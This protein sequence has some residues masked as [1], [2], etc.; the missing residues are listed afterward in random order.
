MVCM[1]KAEKAELVHFASL[2]SKENAVIVEMTRAVTQ[3]FVQG[4]WGDKGPFV[5]FRSYGDPDE[6]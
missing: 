4:K 5:A 3:M 2:T 6:S 1:E